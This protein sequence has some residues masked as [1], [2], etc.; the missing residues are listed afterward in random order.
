M[1]NIYTSP[2]QLPTLKTLSREVPPADSPRHCPNRSIPA[3]YYLANHDDLAV[4]ST[5]DVLESPSASPPPNQPPNPKPRPNH[6]PT[7][8]S[9]PLYQR[10]NI[11]SNNKPPKPI[12]MM[13]E[14]NRQVEKPATQWTEGRPTLL[15][16]SMQPQLVDSS[17]VQTKSTHSHVTTSPVYHLTDQPAY[18]R[19]K[20]MQLDSV[21]NFISLI[22]HDLVHKA[23]P[24]GEGTSDPMASGKQGRPTIAGRSAA[25]LFTTAIAI[26]QH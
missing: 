15:W 6:H 16:T 22:V 23:A 24:Q 19:T 18:G 13:V 25:W 2:R 14:P 1:Q 4:T 5:P 9:N 17:S 10:T 12:I 7:L 8:P 26:D 21:P 11:T 20:F 3:T